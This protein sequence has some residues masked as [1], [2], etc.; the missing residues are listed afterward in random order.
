M[1]KQLSGVAKPVA[2]V[3][4]IEIPGT[5]RQS[6]PKETQEEEGNVKG[7]FTRTP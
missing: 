5:D 4:E 6:T 7:L 2:N 1:P 3:A